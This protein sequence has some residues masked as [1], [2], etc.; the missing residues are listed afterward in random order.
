[1]P[2]VL[3]ARGSKLKVGNS[4]EDRVNA[5]GEYLI[6]ECFSAKRGMRFDALVTWPSLQRVFRELSFPAGKWK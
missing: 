3:E 2:E 6:I 1:M 5:N 4:K